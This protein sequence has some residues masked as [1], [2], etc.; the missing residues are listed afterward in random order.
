MTDTLYAALGASST[1]SDLYSVDPATGVLTSVG[2]LGVALTALAWDP[3][4]EVMFGGTSNN[5]SANPKSLVTV[6][7]TT[8]A[9][10]LVGA[11]GSSPTSFADIAIDSLGNMFG[12]AVNSPPGQRGLW[13]INKLTGVA[14]WV[15][16]TSSALTGGALAF[17][18]S[19]VLWLFG[20]QDVGGSGD[21]RTV[22][23]A[24]GLTTFV[25]NLTGYDW[26]GAGAM[27]AASFDSGDVCYVNDAKGFGGS[28]SDLVTIALPG[29][30]VSYESTMSVNL[31]DAIG[32]H[33]VPTPPPPTEVA[34]QRIYG[35]TANISDDALETIS[36]LL[37]S[38]M[39]VT[40][41]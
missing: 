32:W 30:V 18:S 40:V 4:L 33:P 7:L 16:N 14:T 38:P 15:G 22:D 31:V 17:D 12:W 26:G 25:A 23:P 20:N 35:W 29:A 36:P 39:G 28:G 5:S 1:S 34:Y 41:E 2:P 19:D 9:A 11:Y 24:T 8:G 37:T 13:S 3:V 10:T 21:A 6:D 27:N